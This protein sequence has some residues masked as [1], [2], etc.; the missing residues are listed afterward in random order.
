MSS[1]LQVETIFLA[2][3]RSRGQSS[4]PFSCVSRMFVSE[5]LFVVRVILQ[6]LC[7]FVIRDKTTTIS[8]AQMKD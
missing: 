7:S 5:C 6:H 4:K 2:A 3:V 1:V 8:R